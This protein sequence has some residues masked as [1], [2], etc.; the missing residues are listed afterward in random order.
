MD[1]HL[2]SGAIISPRH[3]L[4]IGSLIYRLRLKPASISLFVGTLSSDG[5]RFKY[6]VDSITMHPLF[7]YV[8]RENDIALLRTS[9]SI[10][11]NQLIG[12]IPLP[13]E[14][15]PIPSTVTVSGW[16]TTVSLLV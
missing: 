10:I 3:V 11:Y 15:L 4:A 8:T 12:E 14:N 6:D 7:I 2:F 16:G 1:I 9:K 5:R 13:I